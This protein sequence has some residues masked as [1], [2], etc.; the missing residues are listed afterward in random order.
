M[1]GCCEQSNVHCA[2]C[3]SG[4]TEVVVR[5]NVTD[6]A[7][8]VAEFCDRRALTEM[9]R[10]H[11]HF[12]G[13]GVFNA[14]LTADPHSYTQSGLERVYTTDD[15]VGD[16]LVGVRGKLAPVLQLKHALLRLKA[17]RWTLTLDCC[18]DRRGSGVP[19]STQGQP[20]I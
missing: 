15:T 20:D 11:F 12:S 18:R 19:Y 9:A 2:V 7:S 3:R 8:C 5:Q 10:C 1:A 4:Y 6:I 16:C 14:R 13:H 17:E